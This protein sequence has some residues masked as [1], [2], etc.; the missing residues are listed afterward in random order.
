VLVGWEGACSGF[1]GCTVRMVGN[2]RVDAAF[3]Y[4]LSVSVAGLG[5]GSV[6]SS[7]GQIDCGSTGQSCAGKYAAGEEVTLT[8]T[9]DPDSQFTGW[10]GTCS[11]WELTCTVTM[12]AAH[13]VGAT[14][15]DDSPPTA[16]I[17]TP[18]TLDGRTTATFNEAVHGVSAS[19]FVLLPQ[20]GGANLPASVT[21]RD[22]LGRTESCRTGDVARAV[23][24]PQA[25]VVPGQ[26]YEAV[27]NPSGASS[28][29]VDRAGNPAPETATPFRAATSLEESSLR[30]GWGWRTV[31]NSHA[32]GR[33]Y[34]TSDVAGSS[35]SLEF[36]GRT[37]TWRTV[38]GPREGLARVVIDGRRR[39]VFDLSGTVRRLGV[40]RRFAGLGPGLHTI[41]VVVLG[42]RGEHG[43]SGRAVPID[44]FQAGGS[45]VAPASIS[46]RWAVRR[47]SRASGGA[48]MIEDDAG[49]SLRIRFRG[50][51]I[52]WVTVKGPDQGK[53]AVYLDRKLHAVYDGYALARTYGVSRAIVGLADTVH[54][55]R[56][57]V[58]GKARPAASRAGVAVDALRV[59]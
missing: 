40:V 7:P 45:E 1:A 54:T 2:H 34:E 49:A 37:I 57:V 28:Q 19:N 56:V 31:H 16:S 50:T 15:A 58:T 44:A 8:A 13:S 3:G 43:P 53:A 48:Y 18:G 35:A 39:G 52:R 46:Y 22:T 23:L 33:S 10:G 17:H 27:L 20:G 55:L 38:T 59:T 21:C 32:D 51:A 42:R 12:D 5:A 30:S 4:T 36:A 24:L 6:T 25:R 11:G 14:F 26:R 29:V 9:P 41:R 47:A